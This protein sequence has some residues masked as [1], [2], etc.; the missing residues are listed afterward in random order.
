MNTKQHF[1]LRPLDKLKGLFFKIKQVK[2]SEYLLLPEAIV[3][4][5]VVL[6]LPLLFISYVTYERY[7]T[8]AQAEERI[9]SLEIKAKKTALVR[10]RASFFIK[11]LQIADKNSI[12]NR[13]EPLLFLHKEKQSVEIFLKASAMKESESLLERQKKLDENRL[14][15]EEVTV[16]QQ[17]HIQ[18]RMYRLKTPVEA[19]ASDLQMLLNTIEST[20]PSFSYLRPQWILQTFT[21]KRKKISQDYQLLECDFKLL[22]RTLTEES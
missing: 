1:F 5:I 12:K 22:E 9:A 6:L 3:C 8:L 4:I 19:D 18:E 21:L 13:L 7:Q 10:S 2:S 15:F 20:S 17:E 16:F 11:K 14:L